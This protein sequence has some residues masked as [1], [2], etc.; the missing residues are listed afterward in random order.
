MQCPEQHTRHGVVIVRIAKAEKAKYV[1]IDE[2]V[3]E[4]SVVLAGDALEGEGKVWRIA[5]RRQ[6]VPWRGDE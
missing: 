3:P 2:V 4:E 6:N 5:Q 1:L